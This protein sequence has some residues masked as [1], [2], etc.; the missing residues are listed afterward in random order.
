MEPVEEQKEERQE[1]WRFI[2]HEQTALLLVMAT[3]AFVCGSV[4]YLLP[5]LVTF[6]GNVLNFVA[7]VAN[8]I[9]AVIILAPVLLGMLWTVFPF[10]CVTAAHL[11]V[12]ELIAMFN[13]TINAT[14]T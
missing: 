13:T 11:H 1:D 12:H 7:M 4:W 10:L 2:D 9:L 14:S 6:M 3:I 8:L 5:D